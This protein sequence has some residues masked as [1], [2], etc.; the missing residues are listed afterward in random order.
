MAGFE[1]L[2]VV[3]VT[4][5]VAAACQQAWCT[6]LPGSTTRQLAGTEGM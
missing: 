6:P 1:A 4:L 3:L 5:L 2:R